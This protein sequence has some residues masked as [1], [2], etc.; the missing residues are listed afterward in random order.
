MFTLNT[1]KVQLILT[2]AILTGCGGGGGGDASSDNGGSASINGAG[3]KGPLVNA[4]VFAYVLDPMQPDLRGEQVGSGS[5]NELAEL[6]LAIATSDVN[7]GP[8]IIEYIGGR[9][10][11]GTIPV[12]ETLRTIVSSEQIQQGTPVYAT[13]LSTLIIENAVTIADRPQQS[14]DPIFTG[15]SGNNDGIV[16]LNEFNAALSVAAQSARN[17]FGMGILDEA[18]DLFES[19]PILSASTNAE[20]SLALRTVNEVL[21]SIVSDINQDI[22]NDGFVR[23]GNNVI[24]MLASDMTDGYFDGRNVEGIIEELDNATSFTDAFITNPLDRTVP[25]T[26]RKVS[27]ISAILEQEA[28]DLANR[29][30]SL[31]SVI[32]TLAPPEFTIYENS[33]RGNNL[34]SSNNGETVAS[35]SNQHGGQGI[36][37]AQNTVANIVNDQGNDLGANSNSSV[38]S[39]T[40]ASTSSSGSNNSTG[41]DAGQIVSAGSSN[42]GGSNIGSTNDSNNVSNNSQND[43]PTLPE[44]EQLYSVLLDWAVPT[45]REDGSSLGI[46]EINGFILKYYR[47]DLGEN[48]ATSVEIKGTDNYGQINSQHLVTGLTTGQYHFTVATTDMDGL[49]S[50]FSTP[51]SIDI[52]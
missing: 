42:T 28:R 13:P 12:I 32:S 1:L 50:E 9:E 38:N 5:T 27:E 34:V 26:N 33:E 29:N 14:S 7:K 35:N 8:F 10:L 4:G 44:L 36:E 18:I 51:I 37:Q 47:V 30:I 11:D 25:G 24:E 48:T 46:S 21:A 52:I 15:L 2:T 40:T 39:G 43:A 23:T 41:N 49:L 16:S 31:S 6:S 17:S 19:S 45:S 22:N 3:V 20:H